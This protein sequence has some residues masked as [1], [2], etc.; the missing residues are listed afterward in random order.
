MDCSSRDFRLISGLKFC[1]GI[2]R[3]SIYT[4]TYENNNFGLFFQD[5]KDQIITTD[6]EITQV[7]QYKI[8]WVLLVTLI[9]ASFW[10]NIR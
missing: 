10:L 6:T 7:N 3:Y 5:N 9:C 4:C 8:S 2:L 1:R